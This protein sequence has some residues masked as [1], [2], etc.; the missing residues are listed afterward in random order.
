MINLDIAE[1]FI[2][3][4]NPQ[5]LEIAAQ[6]TLDHQQV[7]QESNLTLVISD[8]AHLQRLNRDFMAIDEP[9]DVLSFPAGHID[10]DTGQPY[11]GD[12]IISYPRCEVQANA[13]GH[14]VDSEIQLLV[15]HGVLHLLGFDHRDEEEKARMWSAQEE[16]LST[17]QAEVSLPE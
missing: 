10:P 8:D 4:V 14:P 7:S 11:L 1:P 16:I 13:A 3:H 12:V 15:V 6:A 9:T 2:P 5:L 17:I